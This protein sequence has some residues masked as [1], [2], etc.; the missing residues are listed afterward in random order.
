MA[1][2]V[3][4]LPLAQ[5]MTLGPWYGASQAEAFAQRGVASPSPSVLALDPVNQ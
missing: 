1:Q 4:W 2:W 3:K 5:V